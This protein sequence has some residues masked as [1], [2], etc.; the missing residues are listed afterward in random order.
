MKLRI[1]AA[2]ALISLAHPALSQTPLYQARAPTVGC[3]S[4]RAARALSAGDSRMADPGWVQ[5]VMTDGHCVRITSASQWSLV[6]QS[7][8]LLLMRNVVPGT[9]AQ[10]YI[11][12]A[13][14][15]ALGGPAAQPAPAPGSAT[16]WTARSHTALAITG[17]ITFS[18]T[19]IVFGRGRSI[20]LQ[21]VGPVTIPDFV[22]G[23]AS[24]ELYRVTSN[25][26]PVLIGGN[27]LCGKSPPR[28]ITIRPLEKYTDA[29]TDLKALDV[30]DGPAPPQG[31]S[32]ANYNFD[33][34][35]PQP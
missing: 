32:C 31:G 9:G 33:A 1:A 34:G 28:W 26:N 23:K 27:Y 12:A 3:A 15:T 30:Y 8:T 24:A 22:G 5:F 14:L 11:P 18:P 10:F 35:T 21:Y 20:D 2:V 13:A 4:E 6:A 7:G 17:D 16:R 25:T 19:K 29:D